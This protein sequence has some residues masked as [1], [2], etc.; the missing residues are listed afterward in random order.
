MKLSHLSQKRD[1]DRLFKTGQR[2]HSQH[3]SV[4]T[5]FN[6]QSAIRAAVII[7][8]SQLP[9]ATKRNHWRRRI[10][11]VMRAEFADTKQGRDLAVILS[12][13]PGAGYGFPQLRAELQ[14]LLN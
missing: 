3:F 8:A 2:R 10:R 13:V 1:F 12:R 14:P 7:K 5:Q 9:K 11:E 6:H 4:V